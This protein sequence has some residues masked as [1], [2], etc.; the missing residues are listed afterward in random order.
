MTERKG[1]GAYTREFKEDAV[2][3]VTE[4]GVKISQVAL[5]LGIHENTI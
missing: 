1:P 4:K 5:D 2:R 3:L